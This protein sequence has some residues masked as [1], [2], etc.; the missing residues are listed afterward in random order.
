MNDT[1]LRKAPLHR[2]ELPAIQL[3]YPWAY[4][5]YHCNKK[6][7]LLL[8]EA[9]LHV[10]HILSP[11]FNRLSCPSQQLTRQRKFHSPHFRGEEPRLS[12]TKVIH[13]KSATR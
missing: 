11:V 1:K 9:L 8:P 2:N 6:N 10:K 12:K 4:G 3:L 5:P 7:G 13:R